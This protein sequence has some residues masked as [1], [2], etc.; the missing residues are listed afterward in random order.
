MMKKLLYTIAAIIIVFIPV[1]TIFLDKGITVENNIQEVSEDK[2]IS[3]ALEMNTPEWNDILLEV[4]EWGVVAGITY[5]SF[6]FLAKT[7]VAIKIFRTGKKAKD[8]YEAVQKSLTLLNITIKPF[9]KA[10]A[11]PF[12]KEAINYVKDTSGVYMFF[13]KNG[14]VKYVGKAM[15]LKQRLGQH[16]RGPSSSGNLLL[17]KNSESLSFIA[18]PIKAVGSNNGAIKCVEA[19]GIMAFNDGSLYNKRIEKINK[20]DCRQLIMR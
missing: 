6:G 8:T 18:I 12:N 7:A 17:S 3:M 19:I 15:N 1:N 11:R 2:L 16:L 5:Y 14:K 13:N 10:V 4:A 20:N 9:Y